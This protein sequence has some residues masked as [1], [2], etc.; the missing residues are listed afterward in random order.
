[1]GENALEAF[2]GLLED[3]TNDFLVHATRPTV[4]HD[5]SCASLTHET[6]CNMEFMAIHP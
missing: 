6:K 1:M 3:A 2:K 4:M 5:I